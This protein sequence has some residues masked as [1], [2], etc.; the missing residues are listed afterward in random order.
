MAIT[1]GARRH[2]VLCV[3]GARPNMMK[4]APL[5]RAFARVPAL[6]PLL[7]H[8]GQHYDAAMKDV[9]F[10]ELGLKEPDAF[11][12]VGSG[13]HAA[14]TGRLFLAIE[15]VL[16]EMKPDVVVVVGDVNSTMAAALV[17][18][19]KRIPV[20]HVEAGL[21][22]FDRDMPEEINRIVTD[23][24]ADLLY[25]TEQDAVRNLEREGVAADRVRLVGNVMIDSLRDALPRAKAP[26]DTFAA[27]GAST[28]W[29]ER[30]ARDGHA[31]LTLHRP[32][33]V[34][35]RETC[36]RLLTAINTAADLLPVV[37]AV[38]PRTRDAVRKHDLAGLLDHP[39]VLTTE[40][41][42]YFETVGILA[43]A[44]MVLTDSG[45][46]QEETTGL[47]VPC[48]T[49]RENTER[50]VTVSDGTN[51]VVG[52]DQAKILASVRDILSTGGKRGKVPPLWD[53]KAAER[54]AADLAGWLESRALT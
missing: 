6:A 44:R 40:P 21:R 25:V 43:K 42:S 39:F 41:L 3:A 50:P 9:F 8:T 48:I 26:A 31:F 24:V 33:N 36:R 47:G 23:Q 5:M 45:G 4:V 32:S 16:D 46:L 38:H 10:E 51:V 2:R 17:A 14:Q 34:D 35:D 18:T 11:L 7:I 20:V 22:S 49:L 54:I 28:A 29:C 27:R 52:T 15:P 30:A 53:G 1:E 37:F 19:K 12:G 13:S